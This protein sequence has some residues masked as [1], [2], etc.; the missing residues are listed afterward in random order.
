VTTD[1]RL[2]KP[3]ASLWITVYSCMRATADAKEKASVA[4]TALQGKVGAVFE[5]CTANRATLVGMINSVVPTAKVF[6]Q[7]AMRRRG[8]NT[9]V[10]VVKDTLHTQQ[11]QI[12]LLVALA[13]RIMWQRIRDNE[14][15]NVTMT[16]LMDNVIGSMLAFSG[17]SVVK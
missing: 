8:D 14:H 3:V 1:T 15:S 10:L 5:A 16:D 2:S 6:I 12:C 17:I 7:G 4:V 11:Y 9:V 13:L